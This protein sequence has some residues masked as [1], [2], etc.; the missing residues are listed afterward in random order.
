MIYQFPFESLIKN[1]YCNVPLPVAFAVNVTFVPVTCGD[2]LS[3][4][5]LLIFGGSIL[6]KTL[7]DIDSLV[8]R[9]FES[10][11]STYNVFVPVAP[12]FHE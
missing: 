7:Y 2:T 10:F 9:P 12:V 8:T 4:T 3:A 11:T 5:K 6:S 1:L